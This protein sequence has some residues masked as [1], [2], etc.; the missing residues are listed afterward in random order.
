MER[1]REKEREMSSPPFNWPSLS[2]KNEKDEI[3]FPNETVGSSFAE[4]TDEKRVEFVEN[5]RLSLTNA[6][7][8]EIDSPSSHP[9]SSDTLERTKGESE[10]KLETNSIFTAS[11][12]SVVRNG[13][14]ENQKVRLGMIDEI[15]GGIRSDIT[16]LESSDRITAKMKGFVKWGAMLFFIVES[17]AVTLSMANVAITPVVLPIA[18]VALIMS[19]IFAQ[20]HVH[21]RRKQNRSH[22]MLDEN[23]KI[24]MKLM[25]S[26][27]KSLSDG[28]VSSEEFASLMNESCQFLEIKKKDIS[29]T[30]L[31]RSTSKSSFFGQLFSAKKIYPISMTHR[32]ILEKENKNNLSISSSSTKINKGAGE[33]AVR[34]SEMRMK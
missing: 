1:E 25:T 18:G 27:C 11:D 2:L 13:K 19:K 20:I 16:K 15:I 10:R 24:L 23:R 33:L 30:S 26:R 21:L 8:E 3:G 9:F 34:F 29:T 7:L 6:L 28:F 32:S 14:I 4:K 12:D 17:N 31:S 5:D 22:K